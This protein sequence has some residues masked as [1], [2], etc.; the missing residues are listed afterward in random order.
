MIDRI[1]REAERAQIT[2][3]SASQWWRDERDGIAPKRV[4]I[5]ANAVG[6]RLSDI[7]SW[8]DSR[9]VVTQANTKPVAPGSKRG[10]KPR[11]LGGDANH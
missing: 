2:K 6:W 8:L 9:E 1:V 5:G 7:V 10:R 4:R 11:K 3:R